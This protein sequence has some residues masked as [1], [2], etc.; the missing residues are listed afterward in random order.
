M[1][2]GKAQHEQQQTLVCHDKKQFVARH[3]DILPPSGGALFAGVGCS[4]RALP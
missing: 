2:I 3:H 1:S 4:C